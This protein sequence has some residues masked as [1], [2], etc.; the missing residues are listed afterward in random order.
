MLVDIWGLQNSTVASEAAF[1]TSGRILDSYRINL[2]ANILEALVCTQDWIRKSR[3]P[4]VDNIDDVLKDDDVVKELENAINNGGGK[5]KQP[6][7]ILE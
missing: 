2:S 5:G 4:I 6:I 3:K 7:N 1:S